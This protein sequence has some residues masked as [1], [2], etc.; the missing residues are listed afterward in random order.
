MGQHGAAPI[1]Y[2]AAHEALECHC[3]APERRCTASTPASNASATMALGKSW[4]EGFLAGMILS[5]AAWDSLI[6]S[7]ER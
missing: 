2:G 6:E 1:F 5:A 4:A 3:G 7:E